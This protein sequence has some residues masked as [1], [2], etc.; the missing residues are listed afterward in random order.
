MCECGNRAVVDEDG[1]Y[2]EY[3]QTG[4]KTMIYHMNGVYVVDILTPKGDKE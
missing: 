2:A 1:S 4:D 3:K